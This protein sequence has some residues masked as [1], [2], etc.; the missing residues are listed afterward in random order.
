MG[1]RIA[2]PIIGRPRT[3]PR[4]VVRR[5]VGLLRGRC[6]RCL[7]GKV[8]GGIVTMNESCPSCGLRFGREW[9]YFFGAMYFSYALAVFGIGVG[10]V[11]GSWLAPDA[12][13]TPIVALST[14]FF[15]PFVPA[16]F[17]MSRVIWLY[18][19]HFWDPR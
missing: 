5:L 1:D 9:G 6:P 16:A 17:R 12:A 2:L 11:V 19:D 10:L 18:F 4:D 13:W 15:L 3:T 7:E 8:F 14:V